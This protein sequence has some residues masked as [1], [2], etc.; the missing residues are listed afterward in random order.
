MVGTAPGAAV[1]EAVMKIGKS[2]SV[3]GKLA[4]EL[5][6]GV[7]PALGTLL[8]TAGDATGNT[9]LAI[10]GQGQNRSTSSEAAVTLHVEGMFCEACRATVKRSAS[11][12]PMHSTPRT[13]R[14]AAN[15]QLD[16]KSVV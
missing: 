5:A 10:S 2:A 7:D 15:S 6:C 12:P 16:R 8:T 3:V 1:V 13:Q 4:S 11:H 14:P 9:E